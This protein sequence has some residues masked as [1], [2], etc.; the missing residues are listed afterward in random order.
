MNGFSLLEVLIASLIMV[1][2]IIGL[3][4]AFNAGMKSA[5]RAKMWTEVA[6]LGQKKIEEIKAGIQKEGHGKEGP[7]SWEVT[8][9]DYSVS[10]LPKGVLRRYNVVVRWQDGTRI[11]EEQ[12]V[13]IK[14]VS[15]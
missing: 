2:G 12:F 8:E 3:I 14:R 7:Y 13:Y 4:P 15:E 9:E 1:I 6:V 10:G 5:S 11:R